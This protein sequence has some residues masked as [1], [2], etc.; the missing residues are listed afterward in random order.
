MQELSKTT[1]FIGNVPKK[2]KG[3]GITAGTEVESIKYQATFF[4]ILQAEGETALR[5]LQVKKRIFRA[6]SDKYPGAVQMEQLPKR[7]T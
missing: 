2:H 6:V 1:L 3:D 5:L 4:V 7:I